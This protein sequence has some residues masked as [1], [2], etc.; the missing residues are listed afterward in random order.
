[1]CKSIIWNNLAWFSHSIFCS[2]SNRCAFSILDFLSST[3]IGKTSPV[4]DRSSLLT[5][6]FSFAFSLEVQ[7]LIPC[8]YTASCQCRKVDELSSFYFHIFFYELNVDRI[9]LFEHL[10]P[11]NM[12]L[13][14]IKPFVINKRLYHYQVEYFR[15]SIQHYYLKNWW[16]LWGSRS[17]F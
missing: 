11:P 7:E 8:Y 13:R 16:I 3:V 4:K 5:F 14:I 2:A 15:R 6:F 12:W 1:M 9:I 10:H 17:Y